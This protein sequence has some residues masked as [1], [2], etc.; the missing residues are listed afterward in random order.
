MALKKNSVP[1]PLL[2]LN[3]VLSVKLCPIIMTQKP[4]WKAAVATGMPR[5][6]ACTAAAARTIARTTT[7]S[8][9]ASPGSPV[10]AARSR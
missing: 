1:S 5:G 7:N 8:P 4:R 3:R 6:A 10:V 9:S 2:A